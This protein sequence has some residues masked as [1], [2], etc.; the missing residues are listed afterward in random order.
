MI[1]RPAA[2]A[3]ATGSMLRPAMNPTTTKA[4]IT[5]PFVMAHRWWRHSF[6]ARRF[7]QSAMSL[8]TL[9][10]TY[11]PR[12]PVGPQVSIECLNQMFCHIV[13]MK[14][15]WT[16]QLSRFRF[17]AIQMNSHEGRIE[18]SCLSETVLEITFYA[19]SFTKHVI[20]MNIVKEAHNSNWWKLEET[21]CGSFAW[22]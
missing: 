12:L 21:S 5:K 18:I 14:I 17:I 13:C 11:V 16:S 22:S 20:K 19:E 10:M 2:A 7:L 9:M 3:I 6:K 1:Y 15:E 8:T 4:N